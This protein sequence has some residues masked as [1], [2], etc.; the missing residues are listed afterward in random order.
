MKN[1]VWP[2]VSNLDRNIYA[3]KNL[4][5]EVAAVIFAKV[6]RSPKSFRENMAEVINDDLLG[7]EKASHFHQ[8]WVL[9]Y[10]HASVAELASVKLG[11]EKV[12]RLATA[13]LELSNPYLSFIEYSQRY[14]M[15]KRGDWHN[16]FDLGTE[17]HERFENTMHHIYDCFEKLVEKLT[18][19]H[20]GKG[21]K[22]RGARI[23]AFEDARYALPLATYSNLAVVGNG[24]ALR[25]AVVQL[26]ASDYAEVRQMA[27]EIAGE[28][29]TQLPTLIRYVAPDVGKMER[30]KIMRELMGD[31][32]ADPSFGRTRR[33]AILTSM[34]EDEA[35]AAILTGFALDA[36][37]DPVDFLNFMIH[38]AGNCDLVELY[39]KLMST[40]GRHDEFPTALKRVPL[41]YGLVLS[42]ACFHQLLRHRSLTVHAGRPGIRAGITIP[43]AIFDADLTNV[44]L[45]A[46][47]AA[48]NLYRWL[49]KQGRDERDLAVLN[50]HNRRIEV[51]TTLWGLLNLQRQ[52]QFNKNAQWDIKALVTEMVNAAAEIYPNLIPKEERSNGQE[53]A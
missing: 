9:D 25:N 39:W 10:G 27:E 16:P 30:R 11:V 24:R 5:E 31:Y 43:P 8:K 7:A 45:Q 33:T 20:L 18:Q 2:Y 6:S 35:L 26:L 36:G 49:E 22:E 19:Y 42:E 41:H 13:E 12:S 3:I 4:P 50:A 21:L 48:E 32:R 15:P 47:D 17:L 46:V 40:V 52:R 23:K 51:D 29:R 14:Q 28:A 37:Y 53:G 34:D 44:L 38:Q 1:I